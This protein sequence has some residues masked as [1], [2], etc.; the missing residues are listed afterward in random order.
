[1]NPLHTEYGILGAL[2]SDEMIK[3]YQEAVGGQQYYD[4]KWVGDPDSYTPCVDV[5]LR[6]APIELK[7]EDVEWPEW[8]NQLVFEEDKAY[9]EESEIL[10]EVQHIYGNFTNTKTIHRKETEPEFLTEKE[11]WMK[12]LVKEDGKGLVYNDTYLSVENYHTQGYRI[13]PT[14]FPQWEGSI[15][16]KRGED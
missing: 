3:E 10:E 9:F 12:T 7:A 1:M 15:S 4:R 6:L 11:V 16:L 8:A 5:V 2:M 13:S 14:S